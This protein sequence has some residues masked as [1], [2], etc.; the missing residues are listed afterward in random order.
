MDILR[1]FIVIIKFIRLDKIFMKKLKTIIH[2]ESAMVKPM[3]III[4]KVALKTITKVITTKISIMIINS[5]HFLE[6]FQNH[7]PKKYKNW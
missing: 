3:I 5:I 2:K 1:A 6:Y 4:P 7:H